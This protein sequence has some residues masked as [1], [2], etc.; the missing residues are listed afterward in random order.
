MLLGR[1]CGCEKKRTINFGSILLIITVL[2]ISTACTPKKPRL[3]R[4]ILPFAYQLNSLPKEDF[5]HYSDELKIIVVNNDHNKN[6]Q[7]VVH[8]AQGWFKDLFKKEHPVLELVR[9]DF[10]VLLDALNR[11]FT[12]YFVSIHQDPTENQPDGT[13]NKLYSLT[14][15]DPLTNYEIQFLLN[16]ETDITFPDKPL[17][18]LVISAHELLQQKG[19][20][21]KYPKVQ[22]AYLRHR[23]NLP[24]LKEVKQF[25]LFATKKTNGVYSDKRIGFVFC[26]KS[27]QYSK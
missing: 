23:L 15:C 19:A 3:N 27:A 10:T 25:N 2:C 18:M 24:A 11:L 13:I 21:G 14:N 8:W 4:T 5:L 22:S 20:K 17:T 26:R 9:H 6:K 12:I 16:S 7:V 1:L